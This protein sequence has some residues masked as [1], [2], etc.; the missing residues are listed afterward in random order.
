[1]GAWII[2]SDHP[3]HAITDGDGN[4]TLDDIPPG[5]YTVQCWQELLGEQTLEVDVEGGV[6]ASLVFQFG[7]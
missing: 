5:T 3:Y 6:T 1:M 7:Q 2:V 4:F